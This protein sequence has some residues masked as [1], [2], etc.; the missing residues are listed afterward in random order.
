[1]NDPTGATSS[2]VKGATQPRLDF[3]VLWPLWIVALLLVLSFWL[4]ERREKKIMERRLEA[5]A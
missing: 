2:A 3:A 5:T 1:V 4:G